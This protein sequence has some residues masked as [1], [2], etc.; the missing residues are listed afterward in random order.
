MSEKE[1][2]LNERIQEGETPEDVARMNPLKI[3]ARQTPE[4]EYMEF[5]Q[6]LQALEAQRVEMARQEIAEVCRK[7]NVRLE[8]VMMTQI[9]PNR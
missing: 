4:D 9:L 2:K 5:A 1:T 7:Y 3:P 6:K 8:T